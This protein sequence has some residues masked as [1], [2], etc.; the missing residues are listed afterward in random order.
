MEREL[1]EEK[2][3]RKQK[4]RP[5]VKTERELKGER[6]GNQG[7]RL[8]WLCSIFFLKLGWGLTVIAVLTIF[9]SVLFCM[10]ETFYN[11][12]KEEK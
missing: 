9:S 3:R 10:P 8:H 7:G 2:G 12:K 4:R 5:T 6:R 1:E 11:L